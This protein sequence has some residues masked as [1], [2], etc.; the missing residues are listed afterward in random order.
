MGSQ[1]GAKVSTIVAAI[2][3]LRGAV[4]GGKDQG[5][6]RANGEANIVPTNGAFVGAA[7]P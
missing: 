3:K 1:Y 4:G 7:L 6:L 2:A 5:I